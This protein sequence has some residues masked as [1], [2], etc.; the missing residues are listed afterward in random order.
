MIWRAFAIAALGVAAG[1]AQAQ[2]I[3]TRSGEHDGFSRLVMRLP[4]GATWSLNQSGRSASLRLNAPSAVFDTSRVFDLIP[5]K[6]LQQISQ[7]GAGQPLQMALGCDCKIRSYLQSNGYLVVDIADGD[8]SPVGNMQ[9]ARNLGAAPVPSVFGNLS[10]GAPVDMP[11]QQPMNSAPAAAGY[12]FNLTQG[13]VADARMALRQNSNLR[14]NP[15][16]GAAAQLRAAETE[17]APAKTSAELAAESA[18]FAEPE[19]I[20]SRGAAVLAAGLEAELGLN[21][22]QVAAPEKPAP[23]DKNRELPEVNLLLNMDETARAAIVNASEHRLLQQIG[24]AANQG[25][26]DV[27][28]AE[29]DGNRPLETLGRSD[30]PLNPLDNVSVTSAIDR[31]TGLFA[32]RDPATKADDH[33]LPDRQIAVHSWGNESSFSDQLGPLRGA[34]VREFDDINPASVRALAKLYLYFGFGAEARSTLAMLPPERVDPGEQATLLAMADLMDGRDLGINHPFSGQQGCNSEAA[35]WS[36]LADDSLRKTANTDAIQQGFARL[37]VHL[38]V[39]FGPQ[40]SALFAESEELHIAEAI[41]RSVGRTGMEHVPELNLAE[42]AIAELEG[43]TN[44]VAEKLTDEVAGRTES[45]PTALIDLITLSYNERKALSPDVPELIASYELESRDTELGAALRQ[46]GV[47]ALALTGQFPQAFDEMQNV[48]RRDGPA[49]RVDVIEPLMTLLTERAD[50]VTF[51]QYALVFAG[52][53]TAAEAAPVAEIMARRLLDLG[54]AEQA[55][56]LLQKLALEPENK[57]RRLM[58]AETAL[59][60]GKPHNALVELMGLDGSAANRMRAEALW[61][62]GE[63]ARSG[64]YM[65]AEEEVNAAARGFW[66]SENSEGLEA[67]TADENAPFGQVAT[68]TTQISEISQDPEGLSPLAHARALVDSSVGT[69]DNILDLL[70]RVDAANKPPES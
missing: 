67:L 9:V 66:H 24:R 62:N 14:P 61:R 58:M 22:P 32:T 6:R 60:L 12:R 19:P 56:S 68:V 63:Y 46:A 23:E 15:A 4:D 5:R 59:A 20:G 49:A 65:L 33:C 8:G 48:T 45:A 10:L 31:Q 50:D 39:N 70:N 47:M 29:V 28:Q 16:G 2:T 64:E 13:A 18:R 55:Q 54:F 52:R 44:V 53:A 1:S 42:A 37:P 36:V 40:L 11:A 26:L 43:D 34:L 69:R 25:L 27:A 17:T 35:L 21:Q 38:R 57:D 3:V 30:R 51:L 7:S 41:L